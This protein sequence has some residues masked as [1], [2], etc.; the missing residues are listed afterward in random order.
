MESHSEND[1]ETLARELHE[2]RRA[3][4]EAG[5]TVAA[6]KFGDRARKFLEWNEIT[7][8]AR[9][10]RRIQARC[11]LNRFRMERGGVALRRSR[12]SAPRPEVLSERRGLGMSV[13]FEALKRELNVC[14]GREPEGDFHYSLDRRPEICLDFAF[15][16]YG[17][18]RECFDREMLVR[19]AARRLE[20]EILKKTEILEILKRYAAASGDASDGRRAAG[21]D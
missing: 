13:D 4:V 10:G 5:A 6:E 1:V 11:L 14:L 17:V 9:E 20:E 2:A 3:A 19:E 16:D 15:C 12:I 21:V 7:E 8:A 18:P